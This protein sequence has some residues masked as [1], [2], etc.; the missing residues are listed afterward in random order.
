MKARTLYEVSNGERRKLLLV[1][2]SGDE[3][4]GSK[5]AA[6]RTAQFRLEI[7]EPDLF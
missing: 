3:A 4:D 6:P 1:Y 2:C 5:L 7:Y